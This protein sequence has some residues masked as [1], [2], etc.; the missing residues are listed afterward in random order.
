MGVG[1]VG[2]GSV[3]VGSVGVGSVGV[4][5]GAGALARRMPEAKVFLHGKLRFE[6]GKSL[7]NSIH[8]KRQAGEGARPTLKGTIGKGHI[9]L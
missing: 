4:W 3:G 6:T 8:C 2:V 9:H 1:S 7:R 5:C